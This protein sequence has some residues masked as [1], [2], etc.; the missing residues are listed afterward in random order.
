MTKITDLWRLDTVKQS[1]RMIAKAMKH[2]GDINEAHWIVHRTMF[3]AF[4]LSARPISRDEL[5]TKLA[6][7]LDDLCVG[8]S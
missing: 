8:R 1:E 7:S 3:D 2:V 4:T 6:R 5:E